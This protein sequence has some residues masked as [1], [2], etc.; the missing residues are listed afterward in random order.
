MS[1][2]NQSRLSQTSISIREAK[3]FAT[4]TKSTAQMA[5]ITPRLLLRLLPWITVEGGAF[6]VNRRKVISEGDHR[7][8]CRMDGDRAFLS[9]E[10]L[11]GLYLFKSVEE[12][13]VNAICD[14]FRSETVALGTDV[15]KQ[16][17]PAL[18]F[19]IVARGSVEVLADNER[20]GTLQLGVLGEGD[21]FGEMALLSGAPRTATVRTLTPC[22]LLALDVAT[23]N[24]FLENAPSLRAGLQMMADHRMSKDPRINEYGEESIAVEAGHE[25]ETEL[26]ATFVGFEEDP[27]ELH[28]SLAQAVV[29]LHTRVADLYNYPIDQLREQ[30]RLTIESMKEQ[31]EWEIVNNPDFGLLSNVDRSMRVRSRSGTPTPDA[32]DDLLSRVWK[33]PA[34]FLAH[35]RAIAAFGRECTRRGVPPPTVQMFDSTLLTWRGIPL[36]PCDKLMIDGRKRPATGVG[37]TNILLMRT[38]MDRQGVIGLHK[39]GIAGEIM[40]SLSVRSMGIN[41]RSIAEYLVSLYYSAA[42]LTEDA[43]GVLE[44]VEVG[45]YYDYR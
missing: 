9:P 12:E 4:T 8:H 5:E 44:N 10:D 29:G 2:E 16:G 15:F 25:G 33:E 1:A 3:N 31:Q 22:T 32:M 28:L 26:D 13:I 20:G 41:N 30:L 24:G 23:F 36:V 43:I 38:G 37:R 18:N 34:F 17:D 35:P 42:V 6:R 27:R 19:Y 45:N 40:P 14:R 21:Y 7:I 39:T 11:R